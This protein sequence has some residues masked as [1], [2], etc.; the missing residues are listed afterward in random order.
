MMYMWIYPV[1]CIK[2]NFFPGQDSPIVYTIFLDLDPT[3]FFC[4]DA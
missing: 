4:Q 2:V 1:L 3:I